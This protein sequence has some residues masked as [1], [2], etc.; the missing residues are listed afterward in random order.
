MRRVAEALLL[1]PRAAASYN[2]FSAAPVAQRSA[3]SDIELF[4]SYSHKDEALKDQLL[5]HLSNLRR[6][7]SSANGT[8]AKSAWA[9]NGRK[10]STNT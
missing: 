4:Y 5:S 10:R 3:M 6:Q 7:G 2:R 9:R 1:E 8:T